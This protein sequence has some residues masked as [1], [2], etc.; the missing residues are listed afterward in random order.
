MKTKKFRIW[1]KNGD[2]PQEKGL[3]GIMICHEYLINHPKILIKAIKG[4]GDYI[5]MQFI[6]LLDSEEKEIYESDKIKMD[7]GEIG[8]VKCRGPYYTVNGAILG[9]DDLEGQ[10]L[11]VIGN[12]YEN[13]E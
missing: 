11:I 2:N 4:E 12:E 8:I 6:G 5:L 9:C 10:N 3:K 13:P 1:D 7:D